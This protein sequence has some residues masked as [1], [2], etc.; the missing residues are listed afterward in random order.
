MTRSEHSIS[1]PSVFLAAIILLALLLRLL[2]LLVS[3]RVPVLQK[4]VV[5]ADAAG[6]LQLAHHWLTDGQYR[7][8]AGG[9][10]AFRMPGYPLFLAVTYLPFGGPLVS[11][12]IQIA[13]DICSIFLIWH[14]GRALSTSLWVRAIGSLL[15]AVYPLVIIASVI[16]YP[17]ALAVLC[18]TSML[19]LM[20][21]RRSGLARGIALGLLAAAAVYLKP[22]LLL[23]VLVFMGLDAL[24][25]DTRKQ[26]V[27]RRRLLAGLV[28][29]LA[30]GVLLAPWMVRNWMSLGSPVLLTTS[31]GSN[32]YGGNNADA[33]GGFVSGLPFVL[34]KHTEV[35]SDRA[36]TALAQDWV[37]ANPADFLRLLPQ[38]AVRLF[39]PRAL[40]SSGY[41]SLAPPLQWLALL[42]VLVLYTGAAF[43][44]GW[45]LW[46][47]S[48]WLFAVLFAPTATLLATTLISFGSAR[49]LLPALPTI[50]LLAGLAAAAL[51]SRL[52]G[53]TAHSPTHTFVSE[54]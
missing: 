48:Y 22:S 42:A 34:P 12:L 5:S 29:I 1:R 54:L 21:R 52:P 26:L 31:N 30:F 9:M 38:K 32:F 8:D 36:L 33:G 16:L 53:R 19:A 15:Y 11:Q 7:F 43:G 40:G 39:D 37:R 13:A 44:A 41:I 10:S 28:P 2:A 50:F 51:F 14:I 45:L 27:S 20:V 24:V 25:G 6:Y 3:S 35:A 47:R 4:F 18:V 49:F 23:T 46:R 17:E